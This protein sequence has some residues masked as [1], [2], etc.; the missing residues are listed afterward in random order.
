[1]NAQRHSL[2]QAIARLNRCAPSLTAPQIAAQLGCSL[3]YVHK[4]KQRR[5]LRI[6]L[7]R[8]QSGRTAA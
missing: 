2:A 6:P 7:A 5:G 3:T 1:M 8:N 4:I